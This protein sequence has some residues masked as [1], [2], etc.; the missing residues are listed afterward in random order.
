V[1]LVEPAAFLKVSALGVEEQRV[2]VVVDF[3]TPYEQRCKLGDNF[4]VEARIVVWEADQALKVPAGALFRRGQNWAAFVLAGG[5]AEWR[6]VQVGRSSGI[7]MQILDGLKDG[8]EV[9][10]Y[11]GDRVKAGQR[12]KPIQI[13]Q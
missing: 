12:V 2:I 5:Q 10:L 7:E 1:R 13:A 11:P 3:V 4:R 6:R 9:I 8:E